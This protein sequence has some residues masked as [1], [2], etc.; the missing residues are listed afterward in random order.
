MRFE[1]TVTAVRMC[2][3]DVLELSFEAPPTYSF[4]A[5]QWFR[6]FLDT[7]EGEQA[8]TFSHASA[9]S[10]AEIRMA[11]RV[12]ETAFK[13]ALLALRVGDRAEVSA[14]GGRLAIPAHVSE[15]TFLTGGVG[16]TPVRSLLRS[17]AA[18]G[19][20]FAD[21]LVMFGVRDDACTPFLDDLRGLA[22]AGVRIVVVCEHPS[23]EWRG[24]RGLI[25]AERVKRNGGEGAKR[26]FVVTGPPMMVMAMEAV[27]DEL[28]VSEPRRIIE[29][30]G[31]VGTSG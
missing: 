15:V 12:S 6:L 27:L 13:Q 1:T 8:R 24:E 7:D 14:P 9:P 26:T 17:A 16:V 21:A 20:T 18:E 5:G 25:T 19:R 10:D 31:A 4:A 22:E 30:F 29:R 28:A 2:G 3:G 23:P 11:T